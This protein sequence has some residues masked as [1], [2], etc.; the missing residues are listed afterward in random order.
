MVETLEIIIKQLAACRAE[1]HPKVF[2]QN[3]TLEFIQSM[4]PLGNFSPVNEYVISLY[5]YLFAVEELVT[6]YKANLTLSSLTLNAL[7]TS[8]TKYTVGVFINWS[9]YGAAAQLL[10]QDP[11]GINI[12]NRL[13]AYSQRANKYFLLG[14]ANEKD[15]KELEA[16]RSILFQHILKLVKNPEILRDLKKLK[17]KGPKFIAH[18][19]GLL[20]FTSS[21][22]FRVGG[23]AEPIVYGV[24]DTAMPLI[25]EVVLASIKPAPKPSMLQGFF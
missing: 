17:V 7:L 3:L 12:I 19:A 2:P 11:I 18:L 9:H 20:K 8:V 24:M 1:L 6:Q 22:Q 13:G 14:C 10:K 5:G 23:L 21:A 25:N 15:R 16:T 4:E